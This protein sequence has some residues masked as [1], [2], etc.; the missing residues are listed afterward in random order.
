MKS[1]TL[2]AL[3]V[4]TAIAPVALAESAPVQYD[5]NGDYLS[6]D[7]LYWTV[8]DPDENGLNC[9]WSE[10]MP[11]AW[12]APDAQ[13]PL[14]NVREWEVVRSFDYGTVL[15]ANRTPAGFVTLNDDR[16]LPWLKVSIGDNDEICLARA[17][18][19]FIRPLD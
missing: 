16:G 9:R 4:S 7:H 10:D 5:A 18:R 19:D 11:E 17:N 14:M 13:F 1:L 3:L 2:T 6:T 15:M 12:Y 8:T